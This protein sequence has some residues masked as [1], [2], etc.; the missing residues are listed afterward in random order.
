VPPEPV[1]AIVAEIL[2]KRVLAL[3]NLSSNDKI[4]D[5]I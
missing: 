2:V 3:K 5:E 1:D 4:R